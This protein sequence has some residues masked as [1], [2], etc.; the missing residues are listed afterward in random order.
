MACLAR[1]ATI[2]VT[3][4]QQ[5]GLVKND[6]DNASMSVACVTRSFRR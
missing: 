6:R 5:E 3:F 4:A 2:G 1:R